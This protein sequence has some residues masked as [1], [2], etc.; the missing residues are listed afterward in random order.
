MVRYFEGAEALISRLGNDTKLTFRETF[1]GIKFKASNYEVLRANNV[2]NHTLNMDYC[3]E[4]LDLVDQFNIPESEL[5][6]LPKETFLHGW[7]I[8]CFE[9]WDDGSWIDFWVSCVEEDGEVIFDIE[10]C[11]PPCFGC[12]SCEGHYDSCQDYLQGV[13]TPYTAPPFSA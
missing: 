1:T 13:Y 9:G 4:L 5:L 2:I 12:R 10:Y 11:A 3:V 6:K 7:N 8:M